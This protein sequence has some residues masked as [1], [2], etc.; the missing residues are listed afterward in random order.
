MRPLLSPLALTVILLSPSLR[1]DALAQTHAAHRPVS[2]KSTKMTNADVISLAS[3]G[4]GDDVI[5][6]KIKAAPAT[7]FDTSVDGLKALKAGGVSSPVIRYMID[8]SAAPVAAAPPAPVEAKPA[9][10]AAPN[11][12]DP[13]TVH[14][15]GIYMLATAKDGKVHLEKLDHINPKQTKTS[16]TFLSGMT[17]GITKAHVKV[18]VDGAKANVE[19]TDTNPIFYAYIPEVES[20]NG[21]AQ[22]I[23]DFDLIKLDPKA[24][25]REVNTA[26]ISPWGSS[27]GTDQKAKQGF[28]PEPVKTGI[29][30]MTLLQPL[31]AGQ[32]AFQ[33]Q[34]YGALF[35]F[36]VIPNQ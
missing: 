25:T 22:N 31:P 6:A 36:G 35:D 11:P 16:G 23:R 3:A 1:Q 18:A 27:S 21:A 28:T 7:D 10:A 8:P 34:N 33:T 32:Y 19:T 4:L 14:P 9:V 26:T 17:Y 13:A 5:L 30:K 24:T 15:P 12:D 29:Y 20:F 2:A